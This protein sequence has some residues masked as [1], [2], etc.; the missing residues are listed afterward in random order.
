[1]LGGWQQPPD[2]LVTLTHSLCTHIDVV[3]QVRAEE[4]P[5][6]FINDLDYRNEEHL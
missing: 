5:I 1:M 6:V 4:C 2:A 3:Q